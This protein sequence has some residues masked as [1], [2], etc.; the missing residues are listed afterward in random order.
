MPE[1]SRFNSALYASTATRFNSDIIQRSPTHRYNAKRPRAYLDTTRNATR[2]S[3]SGH[4]ATSYQFTLILD[5][6]SGSIIRYFVSQPEYKIATGHRSTMPRFTTQHRAFHV[7]EDFIGLVHSRNGSWARTLHFNYRTCR[8]K[9]SFSG[10]G[11]APRVPTNETEWYHTFS[12]NTSPIYNLTR[13]AA[14]AGS[15]CSY[16]SN[17][18]A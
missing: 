17:S 2:G 9:Q 15:R 18:G 12:S 3:A 13:W 6:G 14:R 1:Q 5:A 7:S 10:L 16:S 11:R 8:G 4:M